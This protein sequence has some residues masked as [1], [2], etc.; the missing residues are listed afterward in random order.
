MASLGGV[1]GND[2]DSAVARMRT[3]QVT[4]VDAAADL[5]SRLTEEEKLWLL[6]G[7][8]AFWPGIFGMV[9]K[10]FS[11]APVVAGA[12]PRLGIPG[13]RFTDGPRGVVMGASTCFPVAMSRGASWDPALEEEAGRAIG[14]EARAQGANLIAGVCVN[15]LRHPAWGR[16]QETYGEDPVHVGVMGA[17]ATRGRAPGGSTPWTGAWT[18]S[19]GITS[20]ASAVCAIADGIS[21]ARAPRTGTCLW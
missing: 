11:G 21:A 4:A 12:V 14:G 6:D 3:G 13:I 16:A 2:F 1:M 10:G 9:A 7:D 19:R 8:R 20:T 17:A 15:L 18:G 5:M